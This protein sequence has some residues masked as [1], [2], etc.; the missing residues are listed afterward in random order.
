MCGVLS[1]EDIKNISFRRANFGGYK[2]EDVDAFIDD[3]QVSYEQI[4]SERDEL[5]SSVKRLRSQIDRY[6]SEEYSI[7]D[8][9]LSAKKIAEKSLA[10]AEYKTC[11]MINKAAESSK[12]M[13]EKARE[14]VSV[15]KEISERIRTE[16]IKLKRKLEDIYEQHM[17]IINEI[18]ENPSMVKEH[19]EE[20]SM[21]LE[22]SPGTRDFSPEETVDRIISQEYSNNIFPGSDVP[23]NGSE[24]QKIQSGGAVDIKSQSPEC[25]NSDSN[26]RSKFENLE[27]GDNYDVMQSKS[28]SSGIYDGIFINNK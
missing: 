12:N 19:D 5:K 15:Q 22:S 18:P 6:H 17:K 13:I 2:P 8:V 25:E 20:R 23:E 27:F 21:I 26:M 1:I 10:D 28:N 3:L 24:N 14:E 9:I 7:K 16:S 11:D 4:I